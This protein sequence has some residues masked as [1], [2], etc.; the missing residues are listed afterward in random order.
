MFILAELQYALQIT[1]P[2]YKRSKGYSRG[3]QI[4]NIGGV[5]ANREE[6]GLFK[7]SYRR[8]NILIGFYTI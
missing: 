7:R 1:S 3:I 6:K 8:R 4:H 5:E 2:Q